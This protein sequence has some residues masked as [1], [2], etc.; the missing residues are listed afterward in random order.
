M[1]LLLTGCAGFIGLNFLEHFIKQNHGYKKIYS[2]DKMGYATKYNR[3]RYYSICADNK[4]NIIDFNLNEI[5]G[6]LNIDKEKFHILNF[7][8]ESHVDNSIKNPFG[9]FE[10]NVMIPASCIRIV[11]GLEYVDKFVHISTDEVYGE[12]PL[13][14]IRN[15]DKWF[16]TDTSIKPNNPYAASKASQDCFLMSLKHTFGI[17]VKFIRLAN[18]FGP[19][20]YLEKMCPA[21]FLR[22]LNGKSIKI[23]G[24]G[25]NIR[26]WTPVVDSVKIIYDALSG[27]LD[28]CFENNVLHISK[29]EK[30]DGNQKLYNNNEIVR[31]WE[32]LLKEYIREKGYLLCISKEYIE[33]R[34]GHDTAYALQTHPKIQEYFKV[35]IRQRFK[36]TLNH[37]CENERIYK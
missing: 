9:I 12:I 8:S 31:L 24:E 27:I 32:E 28:D 7:A 2:V 18:Q 5:S 22:V 6:N 23:Y 19:Y 33:D 20:Q 17:N 37:Y 29:Y 26:Q 14:E 25:K 30:I 3:E 36:E 13:E 15:F 16:K 4:I 10:E 34:K 35:S 11:G 1:N 21:T